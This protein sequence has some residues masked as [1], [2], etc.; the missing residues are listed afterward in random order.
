MTQ[1]N[2]PPGSPLKVAVA[3]FIGTAIEWY[4]YFIYGMAAGLIFG[5]IFFPSFSPLAGTLAAFATFSIGF[6][7]R[8]LGGI[9][10]GHFG[11]RVGR[12][13]MLVGSLLLM[14][15]ATAGVGILPTYDSIGIW[16]PVLLVTLRI[17]QGVGVGGE[18]GGAVL[19]AVEHAPPHRRG[20][21]GSFPQMG[22][23]A[24][25]I[26]ANVAFLSMSATL[27]P[28]AFAT[29]GWRVPFLASGALVLVGLLIRLKVTESPDFEKLK[30][31]D[32]RAEKPILLT[33]RTSSRQV[34]LAAFAMFGNSTM[35]YMFITY[36]L[37]YTNGIL[38][39]DR[40]MVMLVTLVASLVYL[41]AIP[42]SSVLSDRYGRR[43]VLLIASISLFASAATLFPLLDT[44]NPAMLILAMTMLG[45][46]IGAGYGPMGAYI[47]ELFE[48]RIR[49][50]GA[51]LGYQIGVLI[52]GGLAP[53]IATALYTE[54]KS[55][56]PITLY[57][58][59]MTLISLAFVAIP[60]RVHT[61]APMTIGSSKTPSSP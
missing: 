36:V 43:K 32:T 3:S 14:G 18:W 56:T 23:P 11:D 20:F 17:L 59:G 7:A 16:A 49:Y 50:T 40:N 61:K 45:G 46:F 44:R 57:L 26:L 60:S 13:S 48:P 58:V 33:L 37:S 52:G 8:P 29:W 35:A 42:Y 9:V 47:A 22:V 24:G 51:S 4:D 54:W 25:L 2:V 30:D 27:T 34:M 12:K 41:A 53:T 28:N 5:K 15:C 1:P 10:M 31:T 55:S 38:D 39:M 19:M 6:V 21:Y